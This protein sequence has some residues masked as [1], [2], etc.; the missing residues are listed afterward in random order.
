MRKF[1]VM[2][3]VLM[4]VGC[5]PIKPDPGSEKVRLTSSEPQ[6]CKF[7]GDITGGQQQPFMTNVNRETG[8]R[9]DLK[10][11]AAAMGGNVVHILS[12]R[13]GQSSY[14]G[15]GDEVSVTYAGTVY[16]CAQG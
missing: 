5:A 13:S 11:H 16:Y 2:A 8:A 14:H 15:T 6:G 10:N 9:N 4:M 7:L 3:C 1:V 12:S